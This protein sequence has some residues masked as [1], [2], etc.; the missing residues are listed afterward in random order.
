MV[1]DR[2]EGETA[3]CEDMETREL[4]EIQKGLLPEGVSPGDV[5]IYDGCEA[6][7]DYAETEARHK[8]IKK[9]FE[10]LLE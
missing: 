1:L 7:I 5:L 6:I 10:D 4:L 3:V 8:R 2:F 9:M